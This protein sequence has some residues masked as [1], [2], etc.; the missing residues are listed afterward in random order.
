MNI[1]R[2]PF[3]DLHAQY[4]AH[5]DEIDSAIGAV[6]QKSAFIAG[7]FVL[8]F[9]Q[10]FANACGV[11]HCIAVANGTDAIYIVLRMLGVGAGDEVITTASSWFSTSE[12]IGQTGARPVFVDVDDFYNIDA[13]QIEQKITAKT[14]AIV[15]VHLY[16]QSAQIDAISEIAAR[17]GLA[18][19]EDCAQAHLAQQTN[20]RTGE[21]SGV[22]TFGAAGTFSFYPGKNLGAYGDAGAIVTNDDAL[23]SRCRMFANHGALVKHHHKIEGINSRMDGLQAALLSKKLP[24][25][26][27]W[28]EARRRT[29]QLYDNLLSTIPEVSVPRIRLGSTH[30]YH[31]YV[32]QCEKRDH[33]K[34][35][36]GDRGIETAVH[37]PTALPFL[38][39]YRSC[40]HSKDNFPRAATNQDRIL[41][42]P[43]YAEITPIMVHHV[44]SSIRDFYNS[45]RR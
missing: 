34:Q 45:S 6:I 5:K 21:I 19:I 33:L 27:I 10:S 17:H 41:S 35:Y 29:A 20:E 14:K 39:A 1:S 37:Y 3:V 25:L 7:E 12:A 23:A 36:L 42:L 38:E 31:L 16:G 15:P 32:I 43:M 28:T 9:E 11:R 2:V 8:S 26:A 22:G 4:L 40:G 44:A 30:V 24:H 18:V 13:C